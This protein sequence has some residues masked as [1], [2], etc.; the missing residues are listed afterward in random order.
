MNAHAKNIQ[1][2]MVEMV[3]CDVFSEDLDIGG[4]IGIERSNA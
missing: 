1:E 4:K 2:F 3:S